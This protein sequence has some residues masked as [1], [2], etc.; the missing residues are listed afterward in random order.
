MKMFT[1]FREDVI[2]LEDEDGVFQPT[3][4]QDGLNGHPA[5]DHGRYRQQD[6]RHARLVDEAHTGAPDAAAEASLLLEVLSDYQV[7][8]PEIGT[9]VSSPILRR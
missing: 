5:Y 2:F 8:V 6:Q 1:Q 7:S 3:A 4:K 9:A